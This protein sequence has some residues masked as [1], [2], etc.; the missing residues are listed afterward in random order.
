MGGAEQSGLCVQ[1]E[2]DTVYTTSRILVA[3]DASRESIGYL[4][5]AGAPTSSLYSWNSL[6]DQIISRTS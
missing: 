2:H 3:R 6:G 1:V 5:L 4:S